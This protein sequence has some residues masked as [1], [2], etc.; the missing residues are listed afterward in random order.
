M[1][2]KKSSSRAEKAVS[3]AKKTNTKSG[4]KSTGKKTTNGAKNTAANGDKMIVRI[5]TV[6][7][8]DEERKRLVYGAELNVT[9]EGKVMHF[10]DPE[11]ECNLLA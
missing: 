9:F 11:T 2:E 5:P 3:T 4:S 10:F 8:E 7:L 6:T 1:A